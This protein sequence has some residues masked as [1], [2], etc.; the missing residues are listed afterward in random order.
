LRL[1]LTFSKLGPIR[2]AE[3][4]TL[5]FDRTILYGRNAQG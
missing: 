3:P 2:L 4:I 5:E 1:T